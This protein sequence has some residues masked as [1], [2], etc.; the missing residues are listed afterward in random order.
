MR[1]VVVGL[2]MLCLLVC[3]CVE[4]PKVV[5]KEDVSKSNKE[6]TNNKKEKRAEEVE[7][8]VK[9]SYSNPASMKDV[10]VVDTLS[11]Q[12]KVKVLDC[13]RGIKANRVIK[14]ANMFN[15]KPDRG[16]EYLL[17]KVKFTY[18][19]GKNPHYLSAYSFKVYADGVGY[20]PS[21]VILPEELPEFKD[22]DLMAGGSAE[23]WIA[24]IVP[25]KKDA[26]L[27][28]EYIFKPVCFIKVC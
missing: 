13:I 6:L 26:L 8:N 14:E 25:E 23:G 3:G 5:T 24:F 2:A 4:E 27:A 9:G 10:V 20:S 16:F 18:T 21:F 7:E 17:V 1:W 15:P 19:S 22:V 11:G 12:F 28:Y